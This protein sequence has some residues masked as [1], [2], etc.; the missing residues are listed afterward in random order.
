MKICALRKYKFLVMSLILKCQKH[1]L[2]HDDFCTFRCDV[3]V[4]KSKRKNNMQKHKV[5]VHKEIPILSRLYYFILTCRW[6]IKKSLNFLLREETKKKS[7]KIMK[8]Y[9]LLT[10]SQFAGLHFKRKHTNDFRFSR[11]IWSKICI[12]VDYIKLT[13]K[14]FFFITF[15]IPLYL[16]RCPCIFTRIRSTKRSISFSVSFIKGNFNIKRIWTIICDNKNNDTRARNVL[17]V[18]NEVVMENFIFITSATNNLQV[19]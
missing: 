7:V 4:E 13:R 10:T 8:N 17:E 2:K 3:Y 15:A 14:S 1:M 11:Y 12:K 6:V 5:K 19:Q 16:I 18:W 9:L